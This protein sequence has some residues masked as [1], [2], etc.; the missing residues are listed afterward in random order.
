MLAMMLEV[1]RPN[2]SEGR[3]S[4]HF[5][6]GLH[7]SDSTTWAKLLAVLRLWKKR[8]FSVPFS[9][10]LLSVHVVILQRKKKLNSK[11]LEFRNK[12]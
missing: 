5:D 1:H 12:C 11:A 6:H 3:F 2:E 4:R 8:R 10:F 9:V 7:N